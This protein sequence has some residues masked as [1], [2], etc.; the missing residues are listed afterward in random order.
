MTTNNRTVGDKEIITGTVVAR[1]L[2]GWKTA[3]SGNDYLAS[4][5][6]VLESE[7][8]GVCEVSFLQVY[9]DNVRSEE[10]GPLWTGLDLDTIQGK[11]VSIACTFEKDYTNSTTGAVKHQFRNPTLIKFLNPGDEPPMIPTQ[12]TQVAQT[13]P[14]TPSVVPT[15]APMAPPTPQSVSPFSLDERISWNSAI[16][17]IMLSDKGPRIL[18]SEER[19]R[20]YLDDDGKS[21]IQGEGSAYM[22]EFFSEIIASAAFALYKVIRR[23]PVPVQIRASSKQYST[24]L[25]VEPMGQ[26]NNWNASPQRPQVEAAPEDEYVLFPED[27]DLG[28]GLSGEI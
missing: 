25:M 7:E 14:V 15:T 21:W 6:L 10:M 13:T 4:G 2:P 28:A 22:D 3:K 17:N 20:G 27:S 16:N 19:Y 5:K 12:T 9:V 8:D 24:E 23:G 26:G 1:Y 18:F 11:K